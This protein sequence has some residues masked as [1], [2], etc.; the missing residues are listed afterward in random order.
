MKGRRRAIHS[1]RLCDR[2]PHGGHHM[3][4]RPGH[5]LGPRPEAQTFFSS[6]MG[7]GSRIFLDHDIG[8]DPWMV[9][10]SYLDSCGSPVWTLNFF[11]GGA[12]DWPGMGGWSMVGWQGRTLGPDSKISPFSTLSDDLGFSIF[13]SMGHPTRNF[14][15]TLGPDP[16]DPLM[17]GPTFG[18]ET[19]TLIH[20]G[21]RPDFVFFSIHT[22]AP[23]ANH[24]MGQW[25][26]DLD[27]MG[28]DPFIQL[29]G[30][31]VRVP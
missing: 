21:A 18:F 28:D 9:K 15:P 8:P 4:D 7:E 25:V 22:G 14:R 19:P 6:S 27:P 20:W 24:P 2:R 3:G 17:T 11:H 26:G 10:W 30:S 13:S 1:D 12:P 29:F 23:L 5:A 31:E 16:Y